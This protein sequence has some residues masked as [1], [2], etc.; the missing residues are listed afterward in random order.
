MGRLSEAQER[1]QAR[2]HKS[3]IA[4]LRSSLTLQSKGKTMPQEFDKAHRTD[5][6]LLNDFTDLHTID[7]PD[8]SARAELHHLLLRKAQLEKE[9][10]APTPTPI[11][12]E[13]DCIDTILKALDDL[14]D[15]VTARRIVA[16]IDK[17]VRGVS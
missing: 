17:R 6:G 15:I 7:D 14:Q 2:I 4:T 9:L 11:D 13:I 1:R 16:Y 3:I 10:G 5:E 8:E 12:I